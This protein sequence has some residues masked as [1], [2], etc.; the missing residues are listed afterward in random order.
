MN[1]VEEEEETEAGFPSLTVK[2]KAPAS[3]A[4]EGARAP[5]KYPFPLASNRSKKV[6]PRPC[7]NCGSPL[8][9]DRDCASWRSHGHPEGKIVPTNKVNDAYH[10]SYIAMLEDDDDNYEV[11]F[12]NFNECLDTSTHVEAL[13]VETSSNNEFPDIGETDEPMQ[14]ADGWATLPINMLDLE[15][16]VEQPSE[17]VYKPSPVWERPAGHAVQGIDAFKLLCHVNSLKEPAAIVVSD[18]GVAPTLISQKLLESLKVLKPRP[19]AGRKLKLLQLTGSAGCSEYIR[20]NLY[21]C[22]QLGPVC[23]KGVEAYVVK[24]M[25]ANMLIGKDAQQAWQL[26]IIQKEM[27]KYWKVGDLIHLIP[28]IP[29]SPPTETF[30]A[31]WSPEKNKRS[32]AS[33]SSKKKMES[34][35]KQ[36]NAIAKHDLVLEP[37]SIATVTTISRGIPCREDMYLEAVPLKRGSNSFISTLHGIASLNEDDSFQIKVVN[38]TKRRVLLCTGNLLGFLAKASRALKSSHN[39]PKEEL[40]KFKN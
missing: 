16:E 27:N 33:S 39:L 9:Y 3:I 28:G 14:K 12:A 40:D 35:K 23:L 6:P 38:T 11:H 22:S 7:R 26:H 4:N 34:S 25:E 8:H 1:V 17:D 29:G 2:V 20:L 36:W 37:E 10:K 15:K 19:R 31:Q 24:D 13:L 21:F 5:G 30:S 18:L 32:L